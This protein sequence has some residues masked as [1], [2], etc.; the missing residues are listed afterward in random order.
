MWFS[1]LTLQHAFPKRW[2]LQCECWLDPKN[3]SQCI[4]IFRTW[5]V[6]ENVVCEMVAIFSRPQCINT[7]VATGRYVSVIILP[8]QSYLNKQT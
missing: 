3:D 2:F 4:T 1:K 7:G 8:Q 5:N 6:F